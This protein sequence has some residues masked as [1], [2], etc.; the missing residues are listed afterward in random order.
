MQEQQGPIIIFIYD[1]NMPRCQTYIYLFHHPYARQEDLAFLELN[2]SDI[3]E[4]LVC[5]Y[6]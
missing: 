5:M 2:L 4:N 3:Y 1:Y 6:R